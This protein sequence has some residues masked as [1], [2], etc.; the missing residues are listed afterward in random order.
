MNFWYRDLEIYFLTTVINTSPSVPVSVRVIDVIPLHVRY[1]LSTYTFHLVRW[2]ESCLE[3]QCDAIAESCV[4]GTSGIE[5]VSRPV[6]KNVRSISEP[7]NRF[8]MHFVHEYDIPPQC[9]LVLRL[10]GSVSS[11]NKCRYHG[12]H[13]MGDGEYDIDGA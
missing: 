6:V 2:G 9:T 10:T 7:S 8:F 4:S 13:I 5:L 1:L 3:H 12:K 11:P